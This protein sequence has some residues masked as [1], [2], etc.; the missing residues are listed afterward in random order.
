M[1]E[2]ATKGHAQSVY[3]IQNQ[4]S[5]SSDNIEVFIHQN[6]LKYIAITKINEY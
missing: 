3:Y 1:N 5:K 2:V 4:R 6:Y